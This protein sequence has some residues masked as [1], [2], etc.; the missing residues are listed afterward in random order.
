MMTASQARIGRARDAAG[1]DE[2][3][4]EDVSDRFVAF[5]RRQL[6]RRSI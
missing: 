2:V 6:A 3:E 4:D 5:R 1:V